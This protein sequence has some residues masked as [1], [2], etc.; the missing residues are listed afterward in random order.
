MKLISIIF[1]Y[2]IVLAAFVMAAWGTLGFL[3]YFTDI[4]PV[5]PLQN[6]T[7]PNGTQFIHWFLISLSGYTFIIGYFSRWEYT[8]NVMVV[9]Y[10]CLATMCFIQTF[11]F[12]VREDRYASYAKEVFYYIIISTYLFKSKRMKDH[13]GKKLT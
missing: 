3:E 7:F 10:A 13:F 2:L 11:D 9:I 4:A 1:T 5:I 8:P 6:P 12:M